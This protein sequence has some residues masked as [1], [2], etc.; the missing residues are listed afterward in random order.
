MAWIGIALALL[1][2]IPAAM[3][4]WYKWRKWRIEAQTQPPDE[5]RIRK[6]RELRRVLRPGPRRTVVTEELHIREDWRW[7]VR[8]E[9]IV[10]VMVVALLATSAGLLVVSVVSK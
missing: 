9:R 8:S 10:L 5:D 4:R 3:T 1:L 7:G 2:A 6:L